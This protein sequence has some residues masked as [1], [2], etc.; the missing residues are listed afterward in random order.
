[1]LLSQIPLHLLTLM[2]IFAIDLSQ[3]FLIAWVVN[4]AAIFAISLFLG[5]PFLT[6]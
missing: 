6:V 3:S 1:M 2:V 5:F 4:I